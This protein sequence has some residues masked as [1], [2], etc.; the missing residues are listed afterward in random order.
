MTTVTLGQH[1]VA[2]QG[3]PASTK[4]PV[5]TESVTPVNAAVLIRVIKARWCAS[6]ALMMVYLG[7]LTPVG[8]ANSVWNP[9]AAS[10][11]SACRVRAV[12]RTIERRPSAATT[13]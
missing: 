5:L 3:L 6:V 1:I 8:A 7:S 12:A 11:N 2:I 4:V 10:A 9:G 13:V